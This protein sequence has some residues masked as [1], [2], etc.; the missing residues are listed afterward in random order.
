MLDTCF[1]SL[2]RLDCALGGSEEIDVVT[3]AVCQSTRR[4]FLGAGCGTARYE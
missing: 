1:S 3:V 4:A 2:R